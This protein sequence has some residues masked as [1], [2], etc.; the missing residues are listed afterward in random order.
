MC[1]HK[2]LHMCCW[3][4][5]H[6]S[7]RLRLGGCLPRLSLYIHPCQGETAHGT[8]PGRVKIH[9]SPPRAERYVVKI[10]IFRKL[11]M[12][13]DEVNTSIHLLPYSHTS[14]SLH[15]TASTEHSKS[16]CVGSAVLH[17]YLNLFN[18]KL[19]SNNLN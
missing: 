4:E 2:A 18:C 12:I 14:T 5:L 3:S 9:G 19:S 11:W 13:L 1:N 15:Y 17:L 10:I 7:C 16:V 6:K 8:H